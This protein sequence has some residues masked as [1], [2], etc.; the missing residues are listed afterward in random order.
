M[1]LIDNVSGD[2]TPGLL[3]RIEN[4]TIVRNSQNVGFVK[5]VNQAA[6][7]A[8]G[9]HL[10]LLNNDT[11]IVSDAIAVAADVLD[12][13]AE[14]GAVGGRIVAPDGTL[15]D[16]GSMVLSD[17]ATLACGRGASPVE[18]AF[19]VQRN[20]DFCTGAFL[21]TRRSDFESLGG[22]DEAFSP[23]YFEEL[24][25]CTRLAKRGKRVVCDP[26]VLLLHYGKASGTSQRVKQLMR[27]NRAKYFEKHRDW[28]RQRQ[29][30]P[31]NTSPPYPPSTGTGP[32]AQDAA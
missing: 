28:L 31:V 18:P 32:S 21:M 4:A 20:V 22:L 6:K 17:G 13:E 26:R 8:R 1:I 3:D 9:T 11:Q 16:A 14:I 30:L 23:A 24:D 15:Q 29:T 2:E 10:L 7:M 27:R 25:Y 19:M 12:S 5:A